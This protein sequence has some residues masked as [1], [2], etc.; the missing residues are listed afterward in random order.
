PPFGWCCPR[1]VIGQRARARVGRCRPGWF[2]MSGSCKHLIEYPIFQKAQERLFALAL[3]AFPAILID[4]YFPV[5]V[6][7][8]GRVSLTRAPAWSEERA[9][10]RPPQT[11]GGFSCH[12]PIIRSLSSLTGFPNSL[13]SPTC[14]R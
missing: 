14:P 1:A 10:G 3:S 12:F 9:R 8:T 6:H 2:F 11:K 7:E 5:L 4:A 13:T